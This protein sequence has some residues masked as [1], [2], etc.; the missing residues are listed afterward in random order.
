M[1]LSV[2]RTPVDGVQ[3]I[4][5]HRSGDDD[6]DLHRVGDAEQQHDDRI[7]APGAGTARKNSS[8]GSVSSRS[9]GTRPMTVPAGDADRDGGR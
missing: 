3:Q 7:R 5:P 1:T 9:H 6:R 4:G 2:A 8:T